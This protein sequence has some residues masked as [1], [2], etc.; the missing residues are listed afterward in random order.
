MNA[1]VASPSMRPGAALY[2]SLSWRERIYLG[3]SRPSSKR[4]QR[5][6]FSRGILEP[7]KTCGKPPSSLLIHIDKHCT[8][9]SNRDLIPN[10]HR[11]RSWLAVPRKPVD[12]QKAKRKPHRNKPSVIHQKPLITAPSPWLPTTCFKSN[13]VKSEMSH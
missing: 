10:D 12:P 8:R 6:F 5:G 9:K 11:E 4:A 2:R 1:S 7:I 3:C 13:D